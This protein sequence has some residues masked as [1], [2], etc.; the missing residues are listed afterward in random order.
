MDEW[1]SKYGINF[2]NINNEIGTIKKLKYFDI[3]D[4]LNA[5]QRVLDDY[6]VKIAGIE[7]YG[8]KRPIAKRQQILTPPPEEDYIKM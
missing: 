3:N 4:S 2:Q 1:N 8:Q 6:L 7:G 5:C